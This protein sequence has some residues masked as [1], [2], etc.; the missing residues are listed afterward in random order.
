MTNA[1]YSLA[2]EFHRPR[3]GSESIRMIVMC[4]AALRSVDATDSG[5]TPHALRV[6]N[7]A[8]KSRKVSMEQINLYGFVALW[9]L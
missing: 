6:Q 5:P 2:G 4:G 3:G 7:S 1:K 9:S 8:S